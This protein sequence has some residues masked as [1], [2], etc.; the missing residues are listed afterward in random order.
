MPHDSELD[1][2]TLLQYAG[3]ATAAAATVSLAGC[4]GS[5]DDDDGDDDDDTN[6]E[7]EEEFFVT[8]AQGEFPDTLDP[9][10]DNATP[11]YNVIDQAYEPFLYRDSGRDDLDEMGRP[12]ARVVEDWERT[13]DRTLELTVRDG[14][15]FHSGNE[16]TAED[17][18]YSINRANGNFDVTSE[19]AAVIGDIDEAEAVDDST[20]E[21]HLNAAVPAIL[22]NLGAFGRVMEQEW[23][24]DDDNDPTSEINGTGPFEMVELEEGSYVDYEAF[25][26][27]WGDEP[28]VD[29]GRLTV[30]GEEGPRV[31]SLEAG[32]VDVITGVSPDRVPDVELNDDLR[33]ESLPSIRTIFLVMND[34]YEPFDN[35]D[36]RRAMNYAVDVDAII[37]SI[38]EDLAEPTSQPTLEGHFGHDPDVD[39]YPHDPDQAEQLID[40]S[41]YAGESI[42]LVTPQGRYLADV[43]VAEAAAGQ[44]DELDNVSCEHEIREFNDLVGQIFA[45][46]QEAAP[47]FFLIGWGVPT[48]DADYA[49]RDWFIDGAPSQM[50]NDDQIQE[51]LNDADDTVDDAERESLL[52]QANA[53]ANDQ[54]SWVFMHQQFSV[55][56]VSEEVAWDPRQDEDILLEEMGPAE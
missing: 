40:D 3:S 11:T 46:D 16:C 56:G 30:R 45:E 48:L 12:I 5:E 25:D 4:I 18:A 33:V 22:Q 55:Y 28:A 2:R 32:E 8:V 41:G 54:A 23:T 44:I 6:G 20:V 1:R 19:V 29:G 49:M 38:L 34:A 26:D 31:D 42:T 47:P 52:Q 35:A 13:D 53:R 9:V 7:D 39:P 51:Y 24:E 37:S 43:D 14:V 50:F 15:T 17:V 27:Y 21:V 10:G 36:F